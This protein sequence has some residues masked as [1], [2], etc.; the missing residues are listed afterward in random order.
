MYMESWANKPNDNYCLSF[1]FTNH[2]LLTCFKSVLNLHYVH[3]SYKYCLI[4]TFLDL[5]TIIINYYSSVILAQFHVKYTPP[6][7]LHHFQS[8][9]AGVMNSNYHKD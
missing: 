1:P 6:P 8:T 7:H 4:V 5:I 2:V 9:E 3:I